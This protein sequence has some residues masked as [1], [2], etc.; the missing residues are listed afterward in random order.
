MV[1]Q[2][3][4]GV[5]VA[6]REKAHIRRRHSVQNGVNRTPNRVSFMEKSCPV[7]PAYFFRYP[8]STHGH[9]S[10]R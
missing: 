7:R 10:M 6:S 4:D 2:F 5:A 8:P 3:A 1:V 9:V